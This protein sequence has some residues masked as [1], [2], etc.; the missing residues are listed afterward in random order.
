MMI[1]TLSGKNEITITLPG[2]FDFNALTSFQKSYAPVLE[3]RSFNLITLDMQAVEMIDGAALVTLLALKQ[4]AGGANIA[5]VFK[6]CSDDIM[7]I[8]ELAGLNEHMKIHYYAFQEGK[9]YE[10]SESLS[11]P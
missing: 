5:L 11:F 8:L 9:Q 3:T 2:T 7:N 4:K 10:L 6:N 1:E